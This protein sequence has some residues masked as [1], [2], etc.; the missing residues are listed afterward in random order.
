M[1]AKSDLA[2]G[3]VKQQVGQERA[4]MSTEDKEKE[5]AC[6]RCGGVMENG[7]ATALGLM[8]GDMSSGNPKLVF[9]VPGVQT[10]GNPIKAFQQGLQGDQ[11]NKAYLLRGYRCPGCGTV[12]LIALE[13][14]VWTP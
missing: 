6:H 7:Y 5:V 9:V 3:P 10:S 2:F 11:A 13:E 14:I 12:E 4:A 1:K 8:A